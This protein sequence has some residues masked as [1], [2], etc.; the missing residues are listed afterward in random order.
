M[1]RIKRLNLFSPHCYVC[2][3]KKE[4][5]GTIA[6]ERVY[7][8]PHRINI[9]QLA[10]KHREI[11][12]QLVEFVIAKYGAKS[13]VSFTV[14]VDVS[15]SDLLELFLSCGFRQCSHESLWKVGEFSGAPLPFR[16]CQNN[17]AQQV[18]Q[19]Y[20]SDLASHFRPS[21]ERTPQEFY[22][23]VFAAMA[24]YKKRYVL[25][26]AGSVVSCLSLTTGDNR[27]FIIDIYT[28]EGYELSYDGIL[29]FAMGE[30]AR[31]KSDFHAFV[32]LKSYTR[33]AARFE[34][35]LRA[36][37]FDCIQTQNVLVKDFYK[38]IKENMQVF[39]FSGGVL[40]N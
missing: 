4:V 40:S 1:I 8:N 14:S 27:N 18:S 20:N 30:I 16:T 15:H 19:L 32:K 24:S 38:P 28:C 25:E 7:G 5:F 21:L 2:T 39:S 23:P 6:F 35:Y 33:S 37:N 9:T 34:E 12:K 17:D 13:V 26:D 22:E 10:F 29:G 36:H 11:G 31:R 3:D